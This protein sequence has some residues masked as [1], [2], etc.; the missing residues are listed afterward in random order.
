MPSSKDQISKCPRIWG[1]L[2]Q[3]TTGSIHLLFESEFSHWPTTQVASTPA[4]PR[5]LT[6]Y[7]IQGLVWYV[8]STTPGIFQ[9][10][11]GNLRT[12]YYKASILL[13]EPCS[14]LWRYHLNVWHLFLN[15][16][17]SIILKEEKHFISNISQKY[18]EIHQFCMKICLVFKPEIQEKMI[19]VNIQGPGRYSCDFNFYS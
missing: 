6:V 10:H 7:A 5:N 11:S 15:T 17:K 1:H 12:S 14:L 2:I 18:F 19:T 3:T 8:H 9:E 13:S 16:L 4:T